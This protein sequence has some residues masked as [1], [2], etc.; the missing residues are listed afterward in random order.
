VLRDPEYVAQGVHLQTLAA[1]AAALVLIVA[2]GMVVTGSAAQAAT[3]TSVGHREHL[4]RA[5]R[6]QRGRQ[7]RV[8]RLTMMVKTI[9][10]SLAAT[11]LAVLS[12]LPANA[13][14]N[15]YDPT[16]LCGSSYQQ[17]DDKVL[18]TANMDDIYG[19]MYLMYSA[20]TKKNCVVTIKTKFV[21][22]ATWTNVKLEDED[23][24]V[25]QDPGNYRY[26]SGPRYLYAPGKCVRYSGAI[27]SG[28]NKTG[29]LASY[30]TP[31]GWCR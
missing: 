16:E 20:T 30:S 27:Y 1:A 11:V 15:P 21:G 10:A 22:T 3:G 18:L 31:F 12:P 7:G 25:V 2:A 17:I 26:Y 24:H 23:G 5:H 29:R 8:V 4:P 28:P 9:A 6:L 19:D 13:A 14:V